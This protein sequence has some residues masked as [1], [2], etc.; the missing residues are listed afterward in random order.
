MRANS[1]AVNDTVITDADSEQWFKGN[2]VVHQMMPSFSL[3]T[4]DF[5]SLNESQEEDYILA[6]LAIMDSSLNAIDVEVLKDKIALSQRLVRQFTEDYITIS[7]AELKQHKLISEVKTAS[8]SAVS[9]RDIQ[10]VLK[11]YTWFKQSYKTL[12]KFPEFNYAQR[13]GESEKDVSMRSLYLSLALVYYFR[14]NKV[15]RERYA[16]EM[17]NDIRYNFLDILNSELKWFMDN[18][19]IPPGIANTQALRENVYAMVICIMNCIPLIITGPPGTSKT[20]S[21]KIVQANMRG[22]VSPMPL[23]CNT[24]LFNLI[25]SHTYQCSKHSTPSDIDEVFEKA[26]KMKMQILESGQ[27]GTSVVFLDEAGL[28]DDNLQVLKVLHYHLENP[29]VSFIALT[30]RVLDAAKSNR[31]I[32]LFQVNTS[33]K[34]INRLA[35]ANVSLNQGKINDDDAIWTQLSQI[36]SVFYKEMLR[37]EFN[38]MFGL[39]DIMHLFS[40][41]RRNLTGSYIQPET[42]VKAIQRNFSGTE[43][44]DTI[45]KRFLS[46]VNKITLLNIIIVHA[47]H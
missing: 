34:D 23:F 3:L 31:A 21:F 32:C 47:Y 29:E 8:S 30:N 5:G 28:P 36:S 35:Q 10:K 45:A 20:L 2:Y 15:Y 4:W 16:E 40:F 14:L 39:R 46:E 19:S 9:Q 37:T 6:K 12:C 33:E 11:L 25:T 44:F 38:S 7:L 24:E 42:L 1:V 27:N 26:K 18:M 43:N 22:D 17:S 13:W 41:I